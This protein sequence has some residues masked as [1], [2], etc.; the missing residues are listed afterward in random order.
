MYGL[1]LLLKA[2]WILASYTVT[3]ALQFFRYRGCQLF[4]RRG[5]WGLWMVDG[6]FWKFLP[7]L[8][9]HAN[10]SSPVLQN[11]CL[12]ATNFLGYRF[13]CSWISRR[14][15]GHLLY[16]YMLAVSK[17]VKYLDFHYCITFH[18]TSYRALSPKSNFVALC[19]GCDQKYSINFCRSLN[20]FYQIYF[21][22]SKK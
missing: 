21:L 19:L 12:L 8:G 20:L 5:I 1:L 15:I 18:F 22:L 13:Y 2:F 11:T 7:W 14:N 3:V 16:Q 10:A 4:Q 9:T 6:T 17:L